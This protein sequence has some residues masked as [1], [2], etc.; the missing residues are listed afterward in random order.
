M[1]GSALLF[2]GVKAHV[3]V[4]A[5]HLL[6]DLAEAAIEARV[7]SPRSQ[8][9]LT[10]VAGQYKDR[11]S[12]NNAYLLYLDSTGRPG[13]GV[14]DGER[15]LH[16]I[17]GNA[18]VT[19]DSW[20]TLRGAYDGEGLWLDV[21]GVRVAQG[22]GPERVNRSTQPLRIGRGMRTWDSHQTGSGAFVGLIDEVKLYNRIADIPA[23]AALHLGFD[24]GRGLGVRSST[25]ALQS[26]S[27][28]ARRVCLV[29]AGKPA[30]VVVPGAGFESAAAELN[31]SLEGVVGARLA[32]VSDDQVVEPGNWRL[33]R[34][35]LDR[36]MIVAGNVLSNRAMFALFAHFLAGANAQYPGP[37]RYVVRT[38]FEPFRRGVDMVVV[39]ASDDAGLAAGLGQLPL[40]VRREGWL[41]AT[42]ET[43]DASG[44][45]PAGGRSSSNFA[46]TV[47]QFYWFGGPRVGL[48]AKR[49]VLDDIAKRE[50][51]L[52]G[53]DKSGHYGWE[54]H[55]R[56]LRQLL[57]TGVFT[58]D[59]RQ[60]VEE[61]LLSNALH[62]SDW[63]AKSAMGRSPAAMN[64]GL[65][66]H[67]ISGL[68]GQ[69][70]ILEYLHH[71]GNV[72]KSERS[73]VARADGYVTAYDPVGG[74][75]V[76]RAALDGEVRALALWDGHVVAGTENGLT[77]LDLRLRVVGRH[78][79]PVESVAVL[80]GRAG[81]APIVVA[82]HSDGDVVGY[83]LRGVE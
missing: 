66:R 64:A 80:R 67:D 32:V 44:P 15:R 13:F 61:R 23:R 78:P 25:P 12:A 76:A 31:A 79:R 74:E 42:I 20:H 62:N 26:E 75:T 18:S 58:D 9:P 63:T 14:W 4:P 68:T 30:A 27:A 72:P 8:C 6:L 57:A 10:V 46:S 65:N 53:F 33:R 71:V 24:E 51:G 17:T 55:Y 43:G 48:S 7:R 59:E 73:A 82:A 1:H 21:D 60:L 2:D 83:A 34:E 52:W 5:G 56:A 70:T 38:V 3:H 28:R 49:V 77:L 11:G 40:L 36:P 39:E 69:F 22:T 37:G 35:W 29:S 16:C 50:T 54:S 19:D 81:E 41:P 47:H 45:L